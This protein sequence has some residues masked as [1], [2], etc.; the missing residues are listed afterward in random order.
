MPVRT[1]FRAL[2]IQ[3]GELVQT[4]QSAEIWH[5]MPVHLLGLSRD[6]DPGWYGRLARRL[7]NAISAVV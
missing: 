2:H 6:P 4:I 7:Y 1:D 3:D 5:E